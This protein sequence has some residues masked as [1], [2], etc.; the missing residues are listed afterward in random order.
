MNNAVRFRVSVR[1]LADFCLS[2]GD[3]VSGFR[4]TP[5]ALEGREIHGLAQ[6]KRGAN[7]RAEVPVEW[8]WQQ[9]DFDL[10][11]SG[12]LDGVWPGGVEE[13]KSCR[14]PPDELPE[15]TRA[16]NRLQVQL[17]A[18]L[19]A[20]QNDA[21]ETWTVRL[22]YIHSQTQQEWTDDET[23]SRDELVDQLMAALARYDA[24]LQRLLAHRKQRDAALNTLQFPYPTMRTVQRQMAE[25]VYKAQATHRQTLIEAP[26]GTGKTLAALFPALKALGEGHHQGVYYL[27]MKTT[28]QPLVLETVEQLQLADGQLNCVNLHAKERLCLSPDTPCDGA[29]CPYANDY[30]GKRQRL[31]ERLFARNRWDAVT[32]AE[33]GEAEHICPYYLSQDWAL[34]ADLVIGD[35]NY[36]YDT[37]AVQPYLLKEIDNKVAVLIDESHNLIDRG[38]AMYSA[39]F[40]GETLEALFKTA[41]EGIRKALQ[42]VRKALR[43]IQP[44]TP[45]LSDQ[46]PDVLVQAL[47]TWLQESAR[48]LREA[49]FWEPPPQWQRLIFDAARFNRIHELAEPRDFCWRY[50]PGTPAER[51]VETL[52]LN[53]ARLLR[54][55]HQLVNSVAAFSATLAPWHYSQSMTGLAE[56]VPLSLASPFQPEQFQVTLVTDVS[57]RFRDRQQLPAQVVPLIQAFREQTPGNALVF[58]SSYR[59]LAD[60]EARLATDPG[61]IAQ[62]RE[63]TLL[64]RLALLD[65]LRTERGLMVLAPLGGVLGEGVD[66]PGDALTGVLVVGPGLPQVNDLNDR[67]RRALDAEGQP[68]FDFA[69]RFPGLHKVLQAAGRCVR[70]ESDRGDIWLLDDRF[71]DYHASGW[72]PPHWTVRSARRDELLKTVKPE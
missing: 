4:V 51:R 9:R 54:E 7:Y 36:L 37:T 30:F 8:L 69:Y 56:A 14:V 31:R 33:L 49:A 43:K 42:P 65:R 38:R 24:W 47:R 32:L 16:L 63:T 22:S 2:E 71:A 67:I 44:E 62:R 19:W 35:V 60:C 28:G 64:E 72:L 23:H 57:T 21:I 10:I 55:K 45:G 68:G 20:L 66:L 61:V 3:L 27:T 59:Q 26:T 46:P 41:P 53:P 48:L 6:Q 50:T 29:L 17:Y 25:T 12:R 1:A 39:E 18:G 58:F 11:V 13:I 15:S 52:C 5:S 34:W 70:N 40:N